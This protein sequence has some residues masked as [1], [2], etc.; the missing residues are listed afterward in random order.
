M[1]QTP[2]EPQRRSVRRLLL[3]SNAIPAYYDLCW[4]CAMQI[5][6]AVYIGSGQTFNTREYT[7]IHGTDPTNAIHL[8]WTP[9]GVYVTI[10]LSF[11]SDFS[12]NSAVQELCRISSG[13]LHVF[14]CFWHEFHFHKLI[15]SLDTRLSN[16]LWVFQTKYGNEI[17]DA[18]TYACG[19]FVSGGRQIGATTST[20]NSGMII[21]S[22]GSRGS[23][24]WRVWSLLL[25]Y[26]P[27]GRSLQRYLHLQWAS[28][29]NLWLVLI[30]A[31]TT[32][33]CCSCSP[34]FTAK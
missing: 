6:T 27:T 1:T 33:A 21:T 28:R 30:G 22:L 31:V 17:Y 34:V 12:S 15:F 29:L 23:V 11:N 2:L 18:L 7:N 20:M 26:S 8:R 14:R 9:S 5:M 13:F 3:F 32:H 25:L 24:I 19:S 16:S 10:V 4:R